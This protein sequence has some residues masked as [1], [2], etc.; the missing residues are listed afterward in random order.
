MDQR[1]G[2]AYVS[3][4]CT[5]V[6]RASGSAASMCAQRHA[7]A[8]HPHSWPDRLPPAHA[9]VQGV[10]AMQM[11][12][13][14]LGKRFL[15]RVFQGCGTFSSEEE[16]SPDAQRFD[17]YFVPDPD[18]ASRGD[19]LLYRLGAEPAAFEV[20]STAPG[21]E[22]VLE[23]IRKLLN[24]RHVFAVAA[25]PKPMPRLWVLCAG[26]PRTALTALGTRPA[27]EIAPGVHV[28]APAF[29]TGIVVLSQLPETRTT[30]LM[31]LLGSGE[32]RERALAELVRL[33]EGARERAIAVRVLV[34]L[35]YEIEAQPARTPED[36]EFVMQTQNVVDLL[37]DEGR[38][39]GRREGERG[40]LLGLYRTRFGVVP[41]EVE[42]AVEAAESE[43]TLMGWLE[44][45][46][47]KSAE[48]IVASLT[49]NRAR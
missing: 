16:V 26:H 18:L 40:M 20:M 30:L 7:A 2:A 15:R 36:E 5:S 25:P 24:A 35:R 14:Q 49:N 11:R 13:D 10:P 23:L 39:E 34:E 33:P 37:R 44:M 22:E 21:T 8:P 1:T 41:H 3:I 32:T 17:S 47:T 28:L 48:E 29:T 31:R 42:V 19:D 12:H 6:H 43:A 46:A 9:L 4:F 38:H 27:P 45:F